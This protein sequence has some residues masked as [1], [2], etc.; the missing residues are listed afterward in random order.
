MNKLFKIAVSTVVK[1]LRG[2]CQED[3]ESI[4][5]LIREASVLEQDD[6]DIVNALVEILENEPP[7][8]IKI[9]FDKCP[10]NENLE[11]FKKAIGNKIRELREAKN[12]T[13][14]DL[15]QHFHNESNPGIIKNRWLIDRSFIGYVESIENGEISPSR[16]AIT[17]IAKALNVEP[18]EL[19]PT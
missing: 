1:R 13:Q 6:P 9:D 2:L 14:A 10:K 17:K 8:I 15:A 4:C 7:K 3:V 18:K 12:M 11:Q 5:E 16:W 19:Y